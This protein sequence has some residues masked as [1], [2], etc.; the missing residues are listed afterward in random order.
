MLRG[1]GCVE[2]LNKLNQNFDTNFVLVYVY[3]DY[4]IAK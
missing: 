2:K 4:K 3:P 1:V